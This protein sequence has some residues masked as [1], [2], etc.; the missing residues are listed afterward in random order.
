MAADANRAQATSGSLLFVMNSPIVGGAERH[1]FELASALR[2]RG[3]E[4]SIFTMKDGPQAAPAGISLDKPEGA[5]SLPARIFDLSRV[6]R[7]SKPSL[8]VAVN[9][10]PMFVASLARIMA[11][12]ATPIV[13]IS[14]STVLRNQHE[15]R[16]QRVYTPFFN[17]IDGIVFIS[18]NQ[19]RFW[20]ERGFAPRRETTIL[21][22][23]DLQRFS[24]TVRAEHRD[25]TRAQYGFAPEDFVIGLCAVMRPEKNHVQI[26]E[27]VAALRK[28]GLPA[29]ALL[30]GDGPMRATIAE[31]AAALGIGDHVV[32]AGM[33][34]DV[35]PLIATFDVGALCSV[36]IETLSLAALEAMAMGVPMVMSDLGGASEII[37]GENGRLFPV[38]DSAALLAALRE[39][40]PAERRVAAGLAAR[41]TVEQLFDQ[42]RMNDDYHAFLGSFA[43]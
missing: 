1:T 20:L 26:V 43:R 13:A 29:K 22:G 2:A 21:N 37:D 14:H 12:S 16:M 18:A 10:R 39:F 7:R 25:A 4:V 17:R 19:R 32:L 30:V 8:I 15:E 36:S 9:E 33:H 35:R 38:G 31:R 40:V 23:I 11:F 34:A 28:D 41:R 42:R 3:R 24:P 27:A 5:R 6:L